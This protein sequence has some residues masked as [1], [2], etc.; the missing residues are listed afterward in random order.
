MARSSDSRRDNEEKKKAFTQVLAKAEFNTR[1][2]ESNLSEALSVARRIENVNLRIM[3]FLQVARAASRK[4]D[5]SFLRVALN[6]A[7]SAL[8]NTEMDGMRARLLLSFASEVSTLSESDAIDV[9]HQ[10]VVLINSLSK[11][12]SDSNSPGDFRSAPPLSVLNDPRSLVDSSEVQRAFSSV[13]RVDFDGTLL[14]A[15]RINPTPVQLMAKLAT[16]EIAI[17][18]REK[19]PQTIPERKTLPVAQPKRQS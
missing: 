8:S 16:S 13:A 9:L 1:L 11:S 5:A 2:A 19:K 3:L 7:R 10:A 17:T 12:S 14:A 18:T 4:D 15:A 6:E